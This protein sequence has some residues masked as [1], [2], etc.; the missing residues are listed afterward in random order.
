VVI[1]TEA[2]ENQ[3]GYLCG[4]S[5]YKSKPFLGGPDHP[6][7]IQ[8]ILHDIQKYRELHVF[9]VHKVLSFGS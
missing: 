4:P 9:V 8:V 5:F 1:C 7:N 2:I 6:K 3:Y